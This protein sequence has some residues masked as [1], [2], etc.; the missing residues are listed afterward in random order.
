MS[1]REQNAATEEAMRGKAAE[2]RGRVSSTCVGCRHSYVNHTPGGCKFWGCECS[3]Y[4]T[5][6]ELPL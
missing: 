6:E 2:K 5:Y 3:G 4:V 1:V